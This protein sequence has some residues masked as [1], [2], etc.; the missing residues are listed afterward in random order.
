MTDT[1]SAEEDCRNLQLRAVLEEHQQSQQ[2]NFDAL[3]EMLGSTFTQFGTNIIN[4]INNLGNKRNLSENP[5]EK[6][7]A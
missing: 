1:G 7:Q 5:N 4:V 6:R 3:A 2:S